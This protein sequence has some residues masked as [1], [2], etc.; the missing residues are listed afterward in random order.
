MMASRLWFRRLQN[1]RSEIGG[2]V[3]GY[4]LAMDLLHFAQCARRSR[5][6]NPCASGRLPE[7]VVASS[8]KR[9]MSVCVFVRSVCLGSHVPIAC[10]WRGVKNCTL[11]TLAHTHMHKK[12]TH[13][14]P[15]DDMQIARR[16]PITGCCCCGWNS[17]I[18]M[19]ASRLAPFAVCAHICEAVGKYAAQ[20]RMVVL[21]AF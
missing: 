13:Q 20:P 4:G 14:Q 3:C 16:P 17:A 12:Y 5:R 19:R 1:E 10:V 21:N 7:V 9:H 18:L 15:V 8:L 6:R 11:Y 2:N